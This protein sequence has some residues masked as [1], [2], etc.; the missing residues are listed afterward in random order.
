M[1]RGIVRTSL[2]GF[3]LAIAGPVAAQ[4]QTSAEPVAGGIQVTRAE[5]EQRLAQYRQTAESSAYSSDFRAMAEEEAALIAERLEEGDFQVGDQISMIVEGEE[6]L[7]NTFVVS[8]DRTLELPV[9]GSISLDGVLRSELEEYLTEELSRYIRNPRVQARGLFRVT[10]TGAIG[11]PGFYVVPAQAVLTDVLMSAGGPASN[12][13]LEAIHI[14]RDGETIWEPDALQQAITQGRT[15]DQL[16]LVAG[17]HIVV[18]R[19]KAPI[20]RNVLL[21]IS[22]AASLTYLLMRIL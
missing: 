19:E 16:S 9:I 13:R 1:S 2:L 4:A 18:P 6:A 12:A 11:K 15:L 21:G 22:S 17:D 5:L 8:N 20:W 3:L 7:T 10:I 14:Q